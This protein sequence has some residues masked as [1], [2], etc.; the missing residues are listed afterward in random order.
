MNGVLTGLGL[1]L[2]PALPLA[3]L[4]VYTVPALRRRIG[5]WT[6]WAALPALMLALCG[7]PGTRICFEWLLFGSV[8]ALDELN[9]IFLLF[10]SLLWVGA[11]IYASGTSSTFGDGRP[12]GLTLFWLAAMA[13]NFWLILAYDVP[14]FYAGFALM[15]FAAYGL[16]IHSRSP[17]ALEAGRVYLAMAVIGEGLI[18]AGLMLA[19]GQTATPLTAMLA[20]LPAA[21]AQSPHRNLTMAC[22]LLGFGVKAGLPLLHL[23]LP[24]AHPVAPLPASAVLS[25]AMIKAGLL[26]WLHTLPLGLLAL[27]HWGAGLMVTGFVAAW[28]AALIGVNQCTPKT[29]L[30][31][32]SV[33]QMGLITVGIGVGLHQPALW[34]N[35]APALALYALHHGLAKGTLFLGVGVANAEAA[36]WRYGLWAALALPGLSLAGLLPS[37]ASA[38]ISLKLALGTAATPTAWW[39]V[40]PLFFSMAA[41][42]TTALIIRYL[43]LLRQSGQRSHA[44]SGQWLGWGMLLG[45]G[46]F[47]QILLPWIPQLAGI[48]PN[49]LHLPGILWP[50]LVGGGLAF[51]AV[52]RLRA[53]PVPAGDLIVLVNWLAGWFAASMQR[54]YR[55][56]REFVEHLRQGLPVWVTRLG[57]TQTESSD[58]EYWLRRNTTLTLALLLAWVLVTIFME[59]P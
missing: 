19:A 31:Y 55:Q 32:S 41:V 54:I 3:M 51:F 16:I 10:T 4:A 14:G 29:V 49:P 48:P 17:A 57:F 1:P 44:T 37:G 23:W 20:D 2:T 47:A 39:G 8:L 45:I 22:L 33:S 13:G 9:R 56:V 38:K 34:P 7:E 24:L 40:L 28:G 6:P 42:G 43:W 50:V 46:V 15:S 11:G 30:A 53:W 58:T 5:R 26:G 35:L 25:G 27:P 52:D 12:G 21:V 18:A 59:L 36:R